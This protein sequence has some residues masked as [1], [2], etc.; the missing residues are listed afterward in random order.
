MHLVALQDFADDK[1]SPLQIA[2]DELEHR[3]LIFGHEN[4]AFFAH[5]FGSCA[6]VPG[7]LT[8]RRA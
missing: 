1:P 2:L 4:F 6:L 8:S 5:S 7:D 3:G